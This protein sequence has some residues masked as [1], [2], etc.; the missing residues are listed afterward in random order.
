MRL[1]ILASLATRNKS[2]AYLL[3]IFWKK[4]A[5]AVVAVLE[6]LCI[7]KESKSYIILKPEEIMKARH[8]A[9]QNPKS[10]P[11]KICSIKIKSK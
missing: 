5:F 9:H 4:I 7:S 2:H 8:N 11:G 10:R 3:A 6:D 1:M